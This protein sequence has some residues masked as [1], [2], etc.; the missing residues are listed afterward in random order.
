MFLFDW[1]SFVRK[2]FDAFGENTIYEPIQ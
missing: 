2:E 1:T